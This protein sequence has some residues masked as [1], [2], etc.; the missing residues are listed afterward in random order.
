MSFQFP[1]SPAVN[2]SFTPVGGP[3]YTWD[4]LVW[5][6]GVALGQTAQPYNR[7][8]N[9]A[10]QISQE[11]G[12]NG[13]TA[14]G[15]YPADQWSATFTSSSTITVARSQVATAGPGVAQPY[16]IYMSASP[17]ETSAAAAENAAFLTTLEGTRLCDFQLGGA[18]KQFV[19]T[20]DTYIPVA[21]TYWI[22]LV[23]GGAT[24]SWLGSYTISAGEVNTWVR[25]QVVIPAGAI[26]A[27]TW[28]TDTALCAYLRFAC[29]CG[30]NWTGVAGF[31][32][33]N[34][35][36]G[37][38]QALGLSTA[39]PCFITNVGLYLD[40][41]NTGVAPP[42]VTPDYASELAACERYWIMQW[43]SMGGSAPGNMNVGFA[44]PVSMRTIPASA[45]VSG[46][47][48]SGMTAIGLSLT[49]THSGY[50]SGTV[51]GANQYA[52]GIPFQLSARM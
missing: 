8:V 37:P 42:W 2:D 15:F 39:N 50:F 20:F 51:N 35:I 19:I 49:S 12:N 1:N 7:V 14:S 9:G 16:S 28:P 11:N 24:H 40:P 45:Q 6:M 26:N 4:G 38:G 5:K 48:I 3:T 31:Q 36:A 30:S 43:M 13:G 23:N 34:W 17:A 10:M 29:H 25:K 41:N 21:G 27:G 22:S 33:G 18:S 52:I 47:V 44:L 46:G 32:T